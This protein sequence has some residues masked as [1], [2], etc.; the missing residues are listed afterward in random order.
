MYCN[1]NENYDTFNRKHS[2]SYFDL[3]YVLLGHND[4]VDCRTRPY[5]IS[6][7]QLIFIIWPSSQTMLVDW[8]NYWSAF[9]FS[10]DLIQGFDCGQEFLHY[11][12]CVKTFAT[13]ILLPNVRAILYICNNCLFHEL[14]LHKVHVF[15]EGSKTLRTLTFDCMYCSQ[16]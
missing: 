11:Q 9:R 13:T 16:K 15:W 2:V 5:C 14:V 3:S 7:L 1:T 12:V 8:I 10:Y 4:S 6:F